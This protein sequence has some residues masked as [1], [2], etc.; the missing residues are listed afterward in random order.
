MANAKV[1][2]T[3][4][5]SRPLTLRLRV[6]IST[7]DA[8]MLDRMSRQRLRNTAPSG[9][10]ESLRVVRCKSRTPKRCSSSDTYRDTAALDMPRLSAAATK[11]KASTTAVK[12][13]HLQKNTPHKDDDP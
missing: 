7:S 1:T 12:T 9:V 6:E 2:G 13:N 5:L 10:N 11:L 8:S 3:L 4:T